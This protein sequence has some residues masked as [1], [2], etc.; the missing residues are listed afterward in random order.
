MARQSD[1][2]LLIT[3]INLHRRRR[4]LEGNVNQFVAGSNVSPDEEPALY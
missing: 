4:I 2:G 1:S 3:E